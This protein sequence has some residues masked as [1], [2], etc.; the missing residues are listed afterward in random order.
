MGGWELM[1]CIDMVI[2]FIE[3]GRCTEPGIL[4]SAE[5]GAATARHPTPPRST[6]K[7]RACA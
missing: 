7:S 5:E 1:G 4:S 2:I 3:I 6:A